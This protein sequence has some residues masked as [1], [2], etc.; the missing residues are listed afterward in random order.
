M[1][2]EGAALFDRPV[3][4]VTPSHFSTR[5]PRLP[6]HPELSDAH[7]V[8]LRRARSLPTINSLKKSTSAILT[9]LFKTETPDNTN[10][11]AF[12]VIGIF[13][14]SHAQGLFQ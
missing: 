7:P 10:A 3:T 6:E 1:V 13:L 2:N 11:T 5:R 4:S 12:F 14:I 8:L 9:R